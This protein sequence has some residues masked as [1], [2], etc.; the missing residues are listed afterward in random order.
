MIIVGSGAIDAGY[1]LRAI[2]ER[3]GA[4]VVSHLQ[5]RGIL[6]SRH[7]LSIGRAEAFRM[8]RDV[9]VILAVGTR[10]NS[11]RRSWGLEARA[12]CHSHRF[13]SGSVSP[14]RASRCRDPRGRARGARGARRWPR[15]KKRR[16]AGQSAVGGQGQ[17]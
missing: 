12:A 3:L 2:A 15:R 4:P 9:D 16:S 17:S 13:R 11:P 10:F 1:D 14:R 6:D 7:P 8:W 5:G